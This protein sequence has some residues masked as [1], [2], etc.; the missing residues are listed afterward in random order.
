MSLW[1]VSDKE[2]AEFF[3]Y[4]YTYL[5]EDKLSVNEAFRKTQKKMKGKYKPYYWA[6]F[7]LLE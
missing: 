1:K 3:N 5:L 2:T 7:V 4:F 6:S